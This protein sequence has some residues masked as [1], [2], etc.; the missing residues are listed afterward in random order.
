M[1]VV[2]FAYAI[3]FIRNRKQE[4]LLKITEKYKGILYI[5]LSAFCFACMNVCVRLS[6]ELPIIQKSFF[7]N[8]VAFLIA[9]VVIKKEGGG[10][11]PRDKK[12]WPYFLARSLCGTV[13]I[14]GNF[15]AVDH[16]LLSDASMLN[17]LSPFFAVLA[18][19]FILKEKFNFKQGLILIF[20][21][22]GVLFIVKPSFANVNLMPAMA[23]VFG[24]LCAGI[25][26]TYV[27]KL[28]QLG[29]RGPLIVFVFSGFSCLTAL[30]FI[31]VDYAS[32][33]LFQFLVLMGAGLS[34][35]GGQFSITAA[36]CHAPAKE[37]SV[38]DYSQVI[39]A[40]VLGFFLFGDVPDLLSILGYF[41]ICSM[42][43]L[44]FWM[45][46]KES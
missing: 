46:S 28:G 35:A 12:N 6:G 13:G 20:A 1:I 15:Y 42:A 9:W 34:A 36:Y 7:R 33:T 19:Y 41:I 2:N 25:A 27:R 37:I 3:L 39:F 10:L 31:I 17:K 43:V 18:S 21:F 44:N 32:M 16:L 23:G 22:I 29:E 40:A 26:Y 14:L 45:K 30:P 24:G 5:I 4:R 11:K 8:F 38:Y